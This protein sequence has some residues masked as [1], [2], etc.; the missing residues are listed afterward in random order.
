MNALVTGGGGFLGSAIARLL[1]ERGDRVTV[2]GRNPYPHI[3]SLGITARQGDVRQADDV[4]RA[5]EVDAERFL[6]FF[7]E[8]LAGR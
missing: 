5:V 6:S 7:I 4:R 2:L 1:H 8:R 3:E